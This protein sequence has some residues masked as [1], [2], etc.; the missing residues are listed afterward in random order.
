MKLLNFFGKRVRSNVMFSFCLPSLVEQLNS[1]RVLAFAD[2]NT[3]KHTRNLQLQWCCSHCPDYKYIKIGQNKCILTD[4]EPKISTFYMNYRAKM[5]L[6]VSLHCYSVHMRYYLFI[7]VI[8]ISA[9]R[10]KYL[11][12]FFLSATSFYLCRHWSSNWSFHIISSQNVLWI[13]YIGKCLHYR[14]IMAYR[15][16]HCSI[17]RWSDLCRLSAISDRQNIGIG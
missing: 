8:K 10:E 9:D 17:G 14:Q 7:T 2:A 16:I 4:S 6:K 11:P 13:A 12:I 15:Q 1:K 3:I 5:L